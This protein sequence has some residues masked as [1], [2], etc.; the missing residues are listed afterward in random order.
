LE[1]DAQAIGR[2]CSNLGRL[3]A[4]IWGRMIFIT[5]FVDGELQR[6]RL[7]FWLYPALGKISDQTP[8][9]SR[10]RLKLT[11][12]QRRLPR[13]QRASAAS[14]TLFL[15]PSLCFP[16]GTLLIAVARMSP[17]IPNVA[18]TVEVTQQRRHLISTATTT[19]F[20]SPRTRSAAQAAARPSQL[21]SQFRLSSCVD[22]SGASAPAT[23]SCRSCT[24]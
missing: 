18:V 19:V 3:A 10:T 4:R 8:L 6:A 16:D 23:M 22:P 9:Y 11:S 2:C 17:R 15:Q 13:R 5:V 21:L 1:L 20:V 24:F 14:R 12:I 7:T